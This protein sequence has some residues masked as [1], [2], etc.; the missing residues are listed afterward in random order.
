MACG[1]YQISWN[2]SCST[3]GIVTITHGGGNSIS[4]S[5]FYIVWRGSDGSFK[6]KK[7]AS[8][9]ARCGYSSTFQISDVIHISY[10]PTPGVIGAILIII[11]SGGS[12]Y[13][14][15]TMSRLRYNSPSGPC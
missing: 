12:E 2:I 6:F 4:L 9:A 14:C 13:L 10:D 8:E 11:K 7:Q 3:P 5:N 15:A 1:G